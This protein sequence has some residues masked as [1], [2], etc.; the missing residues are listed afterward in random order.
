[1]VDRLLIVGALTIAVAGAALLLRRVRPQGEAT[2]APGP[3]G[4][5]LA[6]RLDRADFDQPASAWLLVVFTSA[7]CGT[8]ATTWRD[9]AEL[10]SSDLAVV[11]VE[12]GAATGL[13]RKYGIE[14]VPAAA[15]VDATGGVHRWVVGP[16][17]KAA[18]HEAVRAVVGSEQAITI[19]PP[20]PRR[21]DE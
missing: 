3:Q 19:R 13:H 10:A 21:G 14:A 11:E 8:C 15:V 9:A 16:V 17:T 18:L 2:A 5:P 4:W 1:V 12:Y 20:D 7:T 6:Q